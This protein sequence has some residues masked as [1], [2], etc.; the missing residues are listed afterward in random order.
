[1]AGGAGFTIGVLRPGWCCAL[2][3]HTARRLHGSV[4]GG[5]V[6]GG[7]EVDDLRLV[8]YTLNPVER[9]LQRASAEPSPYLERLLSLHASASD[10]R[11][12]SRLSARV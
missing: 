10:S 1:M 9:L 2:M 11:M 7:G 3:T 6:N 4:W 12:L 8:T 5:A